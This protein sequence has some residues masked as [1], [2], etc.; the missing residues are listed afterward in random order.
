MPSSFALSVAD[1][2]RISG[3]QR[4]FPLCIAECLIDMPE[5]CTEVAYLDNEG[6]LLPLPLQEAYEEGGYVVYS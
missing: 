2:A 5:S 1:E 6:L 3:I 4:C